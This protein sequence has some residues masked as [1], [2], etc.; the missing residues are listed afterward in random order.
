MNIKPVRPDNNAANNPI[1]ATTGSLEQR[2]VVRLPA[3]KNALP[4]SITSQ[5][6]TKAPG[7]ASLKGRCQ[8]PGPAPLEKQIKKPGS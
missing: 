1:P 4:A 3:K 8:S 6:S 5:I 7:K 2:T